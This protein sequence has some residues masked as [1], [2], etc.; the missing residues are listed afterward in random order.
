ME[1]VTV[2]VSGMGHG[3]MAFGRDA[4]KRMVFVPYAIPGETVR[5][6]IVEDKQRFARGRLLEVIAASPERVAPR[7]PHFPLCGHSAY[8]HIAYPAQLRFKQAVVRDQLE[9][10]GGLKDAPV[11]ATLANPEPWGNC[12]DV[13]LYPA[14]GGGL[15][16]WSPAAGQVTAVQTCPLLRPILVELLQ[17]IDMELP[18]LRKLTLRA[19]DGDELLAALEIDEVEPPEMETDFPISVAIVLPDGSAANLIGDNDVVQVVK[20]R[21]FRVSAGSFFYPSP[22]AAGLLVDEVVRQAGLTGQERV[23]E[24]FSGVGLLTAF[25]AQGAAEVVT[26]EANADSVADM[27]ANLAESNN[28]AV[29]EGPVAAVLPELAGEVDVVVVDPPESGLPA[30]VVREIVAKRPVRVVYVSSDPADLARSGAVLAKAGYRPDHV[31]PID[32]YPQTHHVL[33]VA[34]WGREGK[35]ARRRKDRQQGSRLG[36]RRPGKPRADQAA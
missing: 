14:A 29:Y 10:I 4:A 17:D 6:E 22:A 9:R 33:A 3:G 34:A 11:A 27:V 2:K 31:Q 36:Q 8:Q 20:G 24:L 19:G 32:M 35:G 15:G 5:V 30:E 18:G 16:F 25:L 12:V 26:V 21:E 28:V 1:T 23:L 7:C 13:S